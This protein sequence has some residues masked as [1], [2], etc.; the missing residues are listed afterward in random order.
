MNKIRQFAAID[1]AGTIS[2]QEGPVPEPGRGEILVEVRAS[3]ISSGTELGG[4]KR[5]RENP[6]SGGPR[7]FGYQNAGVVIAKGEECDEFQ[8]GDRVACMGGGYA[9]HTNYACVPKNLS[10]LIPDGVTYEEAATNHLAATALHAIRR[11]QLEFGENVAIFGLGTVGQFAGQLASLSG[12]HVMGIDRFP[13]RLKIAEE[14]GADLAVSFMTDDPVKVSAE[15]TRGYGMDAAIVCFGGDGNSALA[16]VKKMMKVSPDT[17]IMGRLVV[18]GG[19]SMTMSFGAA[20]G[21]MDIRSSA[22]PGPGYHDEEYERGHDYPPVF[23]QWTTKR[24]LEEVLRAMAEGKLKAKPLIS[25]EYA[26]AEA[27]EACEKII[28][29]P[30]ETLAVILKP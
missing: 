18:V 25:D 4:V 28:Q 29:T 7:P 19:A 9:L 10:V 27:P 21:N 23:V 2:I 13:L 20:L 11:A 30:E 14:T 17:H 6:G 26:L 24:N 5:R 16:L 8:V 12:T 22:R 1:G 15:F 3:C